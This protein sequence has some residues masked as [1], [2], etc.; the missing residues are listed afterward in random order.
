MWAHSLA[1][2]RGLVSKWVLPASWGGGHRCCFNP[3][4]AP[5]QPIAQELPYATAAAQDKE[6]YLVIKYVFDYVSNQA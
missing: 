3:A 2:L 1:L 4:A 5:I 6:K